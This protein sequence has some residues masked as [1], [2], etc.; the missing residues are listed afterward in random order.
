MELKKSVTI[1]PGVGPA[2]KEA[3]QK[4]GITTVK[5]LLYWLPRKYIDCTNPTLIESLQYGQ[6]TAI[7]ADIKSVSKRIGRNC[8]AIVQAIL[9][10][11]TGTIEAIWFNQPYIETVLRQMKRALFVGRIQSH[12]QSRRPIISA[13]KIELQPTVIPV[14]P[15]T[16]GLTSRQINKL[17]LAVLDKTTLKETLLKKD[18]KRLDLIDLNK[19]LRFLHHPANLDEVSAGRRRVIFD[20]LFRLQLKLAKIKQQY[21]QQTATIVLAD[22]ELLKQFTQSL[23]FELT[24]DQKKAIWQMSLQMQSG[25]PM[26][27]LLNGDV[28]SGK[29]VVVAAL[30]LLVHRAKGRTVVMAPTEILAMQHSQSLSAMLNDFGLQVGL[31]TANTKNISADVLVGTHALISDDLPLDNV[32][33]VVVDEQHR[34]GVAQREK[35]RAKAHNPHFLTLTATPIPR[36]LALILFGDL[37]ITLLR[38]M[39]ANRLPIQTTVLRPNTEHLA[40]DAIREAARR[41]EQSFVICPLIEEQSGD[42]IVVDERKSVNEVYKRF[43][44]EI[45]PNLKMKVL[46]GQVESAEKEKILSA[47]QKGQFDILISTSVVE[48]GVDIPQATVMLI[49]GSENFGIAQLH[50]LRG[51]I[52]R[53]HLPAQCFFL[54]RQDIDR[55]LERA[56]KVAESNDGFSLAQYDLETR[57]PG[58]LVGLAQKGLNHLFLAD[59][60]FGLLAQAQDLARQKVGLQK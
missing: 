15:L 60:D 2:K 21:L 25:T 33:L 44:S 11:E 39:P 36:S 55:S 38:E 10:D 13:P 52:G 51:R 50:Q 5:D 54:V 17:A 43:K 16:A 29:T 19:A 18:L 35:L 20:Q 23:P 58:E 45:F 56:Q 49:E 8:R 41:G 59:L 40:F 27:R 4:I 37:D 48:V 12:Y 34:F 42:S 9:Q 24:N 22:A 26:H 57:G 6:T 31:V 28:G 1:L 46:H 14:Y 3:L 7:L 53:R 32:A 30:A 47:F